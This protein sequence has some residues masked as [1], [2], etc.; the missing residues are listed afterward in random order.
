MIPYFNRLAESFFLYKNVKNFGRKCSGKVL[1]NPFKNDFLFETESVMQKKK[2]A[3]LN[4]ELKQSV[5]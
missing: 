5:V 3:F 4:A 1:A 2:L